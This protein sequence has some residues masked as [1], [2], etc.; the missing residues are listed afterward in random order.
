[1]K[2]YLKNNK[3]VSVLKRYGGNL[4]DRLSK[5]IPNPVSTGQIRSSVQNNLGATA[6]GVSSALFSGLTPIGFANL[7]VSAVGFAATNYH[8]YYAKKQIFNETT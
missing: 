1:M 4:I 6:A 7:A 3:I 5:D 8:I 2:L